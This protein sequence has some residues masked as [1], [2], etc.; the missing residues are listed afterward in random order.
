MFWA[1]PIQL[2]YEWFTHVL[3]P[4]VCQGNHG[5]SYHVFFFFRH[6]TQLTMLL[7]GGSTIPAQPHLG[8]SSGYLWHY[9][10]GQART[11]CSLCLRPRFVMYSV[12]HKQCHMQ[13]SRCH[14]YFHLI[15]YATTCNILRHCHYPSFQRQTLPDG[16][17]RRV[18]PFLP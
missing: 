4:L 13:H 1:H 15:A 18:A 8:Y 2:W 3:R 10:H 17:S 9:W 11:T 12:L 14:N 5:P 6:Y 7:R 16:S